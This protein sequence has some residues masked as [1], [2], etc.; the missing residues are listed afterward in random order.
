VAAKKATSN[1]K[2]EPPSCIVLTRLS[3]FLFWINCLG[4][5]KVEKK[6]GPYIEREEE[7]GI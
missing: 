3:F 1:E 5:R 6:T 7:A 4:K 2:E